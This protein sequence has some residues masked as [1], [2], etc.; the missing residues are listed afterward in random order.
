MFN[1]ISIFIVLYIQQ[2]SILGLIVYNDYIFN[3]IDMKI[4]FSNNKR[5]NS[6]KKLTNVIKLMNVSI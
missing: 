4:C 6:Y 1:K 5:I 2:P 3:Y